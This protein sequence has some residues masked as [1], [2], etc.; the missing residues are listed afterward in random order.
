LSPGVGDGYPSSWD[1]DNVS[2]E[3]EKVG[4]DSRRKL[5]KL[6]LMNV[7]LRSPGTS[8]SCLH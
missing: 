2:E 1:I 4:V 7:L 3:E 5:S 6:T 8:G